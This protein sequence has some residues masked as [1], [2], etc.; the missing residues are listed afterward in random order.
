MCCKTTLH[1]FVT[2][3]LVQQTLVLVALLP[4]VAKQVPYR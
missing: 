3:L 2:L 1:A 4:V